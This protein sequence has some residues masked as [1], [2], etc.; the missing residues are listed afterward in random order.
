MAISK[1]LCMA[2]VSGENRLYELA[3]ALSLAL[4][5]LSVV[6]YWGCFRA[7]FDGAPGL[8]SQY[9]VVTGTANIVLG[10]LVAILFHPQCPANC[11]LE[12]CASQQIP[13]PWYALG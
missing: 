10:V 6:T 9:F 12:V 7:K 3:V 4:T 5:T 11:S 1:L 2:Q 8:A 13:S